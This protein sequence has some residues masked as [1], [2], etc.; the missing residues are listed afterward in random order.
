MK[1]LRRL[2][3]K[4]AKLFEKGGKL[5]KLYPLWEANDTFLFTPGEVTKHAS[6]ARDGLDLK[7]M[8]MTVV[9]ALG[10]CLYMALYNTGYQA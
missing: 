4:Q 5:E 3:D 2:L 6:H 9:V 7:R 8:M 10:G 1:F